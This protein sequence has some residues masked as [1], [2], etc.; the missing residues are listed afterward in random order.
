V[1]REFQLTVCDIFTICKTMNKN[2]CVLTNDCEE[3]PFE[4]QFRDTTPGDI[5]VIE[6]V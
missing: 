1:I 6:V 5:I 2:R 3:C 4:S